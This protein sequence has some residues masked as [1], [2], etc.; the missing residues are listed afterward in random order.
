MI[1]GCQI[2]L[3]ISTFYLI[4]AAPAPQEADVVP[5]VHQEIEALPYVHDV[6]GGKGLSSRLEI[7]NLIK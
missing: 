3:F 6:T 2:Q 4:S 7:S 1:Q 5:Y